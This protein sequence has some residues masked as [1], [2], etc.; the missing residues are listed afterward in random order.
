MKDGKHVIARVADSHMPTSIMESEVRQPFF[1]RYGG[2]SGYETLLC[3]QIATMQWVRERTSIPVPKILAY[4]LD[5]SHALGAHMLL[6]KVRVHFR[7]LHHC[8]WFRWSQMTSF[9]LCT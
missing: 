4:E 1:W 5:Q 3:E 6:E 7:S 8:F 9:F 2:D